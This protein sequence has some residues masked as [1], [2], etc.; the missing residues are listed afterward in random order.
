MHWTWMNPTPLGQGA[1][2]L[3]LTSF[4]RRLIVEPT[5]RELWRV[6]VLVWEST[7]HVADSAE[8]T[9]PGMP[10]ARPRVGEPLVF[11]VRKA[12]E[13][14]NAVAGI[15]LGRTSNNDLVIP[16]ESVSRFHGILQLDDGSGQWSLVDAGSRNGTF[17]RGDRLKPNVR[18]ALGEAESLVLGSVAV[19][20]FQPEAF[21][22][23]LEALTEVRSA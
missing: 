6:P 16:D 5:F 9:L 17:V 8:V 7:G 14:L 21:F 23:Y 12:P 2:G 1:T 4:A 19:R 11:E 20:F 22:R 13:A 3:P 10:P 15:T 18:F